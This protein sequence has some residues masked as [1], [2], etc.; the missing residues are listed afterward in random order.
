MKTFAEAMVD[1]VQATDENCVPVHLYHGNW[2]ADSLRE[3]TRPFAAT[4][5]SP[6][7]VHIGG[8]HA[9]AAAWENLAKLAIATAAALREGR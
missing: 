6:E 9:E 3:T 7:T 1:V 8:P 4:M 2:T 5:A